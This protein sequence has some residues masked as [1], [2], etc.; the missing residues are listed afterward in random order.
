MS[1]SQQKKDIIAAFLDPD[2]GIHTLSIPEIFE[3]YAA[4][5]GVQHPGTSIQA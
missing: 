4:D 2:S 3:E 1:E 5:H